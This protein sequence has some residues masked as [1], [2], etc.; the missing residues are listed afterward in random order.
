MH[1][2]NW[3]LLALLFWL[4]LLLS[5]FYL[6]LIF[7]FWLN[8]LTL[9]VFNFA[10]IITLLLIKTII[11]YQS[12][13]TQPSQLTR[14]INLTIFLKNTQNKTNKIITFYSRRIPYKNQ[15]LLGPGHSN[16][17]S[18]LITKKS[19]FLLEI[20]SNTTENNHLFFSSLV[21]INRA[22][23]RPNI[24][25]LGKHL[26]KKIHLSNIRSD[27]ANLVFFYLKILL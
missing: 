18:S 7:N 4:F 23:F 25:T 24:T 15:H 1:F 5:S 19:N 2:L 22:N 17:K 20:T 21:A 27:Y 8:F 6:F 13:N 11:I 14:L 26:S 10:T 16:I 12:I 9:I 3:L